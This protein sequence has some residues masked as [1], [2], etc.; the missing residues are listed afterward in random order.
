MVFDTAPTG[1]TVRLLSL[2]ELLGR[3][4]DGLV[5]RRRKVRS[6]G[7]MWRNVAGAAAGAARTDDDP[8]LDALERRQDRFR[9]AR[10]IVTDP[11]R[12]AFVFVVTPERLAIL[13]TRKAGDALRRSEIPVAAVLVNRVLPDDADGSF[14]A[15]RRARQ[16][17]YLDQIDAAFDDLP[18]IRVPLMPGDVEG[19]PALR[20]VID[21]LAGG[22]PGAPAGRL[23]P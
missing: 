5:S 17:R 20:T 4:I 11:D 2:P 16:T 7:R 12:T 18:R 13:E 19:L 6:L 10:A 22:G 15:Q 21:V 8:V 9:A 23:S 1:H 14:V 3:W